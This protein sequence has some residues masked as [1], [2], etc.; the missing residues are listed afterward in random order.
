MVIASPLVKGILYIKG[1]DF[2]ISETLKVMANELFPKTSDTDYR[3]K[4]Y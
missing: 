4:I 1:E 2:D 3:E